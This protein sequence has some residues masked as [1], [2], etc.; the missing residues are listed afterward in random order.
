MANH[1]TKTPLREH[2]LLDPRGKPVGVYLSM[3][4]YRKLRSLV[5]DYLDHQWF[6]RRKHEKPLPFK[7][8]LNDLKRKGIL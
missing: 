8:V 1:A 3:R 7:R 6:E 5:G 4:D 2:V